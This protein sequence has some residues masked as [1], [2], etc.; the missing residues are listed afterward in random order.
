MK[1]RFTPIYKRVHSYHKVGDLMMHLVPAEKPERRSRR[2]DQEKPPP[3]PTPLELQML[4]DLQPVF[5][6]MMEDFEVTMRLELPS[7]VSA[8]AVRDSRAATRIITL[9]SFTSDDLDANGQRFI[10]NEEVLLS[11][12]RGRFGD[13]VITENVRGFP[14]NKMLPV[15]RGDIYGIGRFRIKPT[16]ALFKK[17]YAGRPKS[18]GGDQ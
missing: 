5:V 6:D 18:Q 14:G 4:R 12:M 9:I 16:R 3:P 13:A 8:G 17:Y 15:F 11:L 2:D 1:L 10:E 7:A